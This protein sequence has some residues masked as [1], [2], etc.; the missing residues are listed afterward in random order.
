M[1]PVDELLK[2]DEFR[3]SGHYDN[4]WIMDNQM[5]PNALWLA[6]W[7]CSGM[8]LKEGMKVLDLGCGKAMTSIFMA[9][10][11]G[12]QVWAADLWINPDNNFRRICEAGLDKTVYPIKA[13]AHSL[14]F[15]AGFFDAVISID[16]YQY[17]GTDQLYMSYISRFIKNGGLMGIVVPSLMKEIHGDI[18][19]HLN[20]PQKNGKVF[21]DNACYSF[22]TASFWKRLWKTSGVLEDV[23]AEI[24]PDGWRHWRDFEKALELAGKSI[25][26]SDAQALENDGGE[27][28][29]FAK[30]TAT[31]SCDDEYNLYDP[32]LGAVAGVDK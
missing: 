6:E 32:N 31:K 2:K 16:S 29:C 25:F 17:Y 18:P 27:Y 20:I 22:K 3:R 26:P 21:W 24:L 5:G 11:F 30:I 19:E 10:E 4:E 13:E 28:I 7:L 23:K 14:P 1:K 9:R 8:E 15:S 12:V